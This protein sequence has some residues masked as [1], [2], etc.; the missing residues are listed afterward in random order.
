MEYREAQTCLIVVLGSPG[1]LQNWKPPPGLLYKLKFDTAIF[2][3]KRASGVSVMICNV[4][5]EVMATLLARREVVDDSEKAE[6]L[7]CRKALEFVVDAGFSELIVEGDNAIV[8]QAISSTH[9]NLSRLGLIYEDICCLA[10]TLRYVSFSCVRRSANSVAHSLARYAS[11]LNDEV[12]WLEE[13]P[14][15]AHEA[16]YLDSSFLDE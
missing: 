9:P 4:E 6:V 7:A 15:P 13:S 11:L 8:M 12:V 2:A 1:I 3:S 16:L 5:G 10:A 14:S